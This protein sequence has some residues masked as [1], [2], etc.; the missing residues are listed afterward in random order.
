[1]INTFAS[2]LSYFRKR[3]GLSQQKLADA[4]GISR[5]A[6]ANYEQ[7]RREPDFETEEKIADYFNVDINT[8]RG[9]PAPVMTKE[10][11]DLL[12]EY[13]KLAQPERALVRRLITYIKAFKALQINKK[14]NSDSLIELLAGLMD[15]H[16]V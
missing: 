16:K 13:E 7:G 12:I 15:E 9:Y 5:S 11:N 4:L 10:L 1:M 6:L 8:L 3:D 14:D 2:N